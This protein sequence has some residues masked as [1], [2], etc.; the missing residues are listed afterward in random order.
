MNDIGIYVYV[1]VGK[2]AR[3]RARERER[4]AMLLLVLLDTIASDQRQEFFSRFGVIS[5]DSEH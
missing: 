3:E 1:H 5:E 2:R 4:D